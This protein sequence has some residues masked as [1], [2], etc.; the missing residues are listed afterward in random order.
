[1]TEKPQEARIGVGCFVILKG[2]ATTPDRLLIGRRKGSH[3]ISSFKE[4]FEECAIREV[5]VETGLTLSTAEFA[6]ATND[7]MTGDTINSCVKDFE[8]LFIRHSSHDR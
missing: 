8:Q 4:S 2:T 6:T 3:D 1:M 5:Y 7:A